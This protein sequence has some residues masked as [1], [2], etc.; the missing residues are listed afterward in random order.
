MAKTK[1]Q[2]EKDLEKI[3]KSLSEMK[4]LVFVDY[5]GV[6]VNEVN[7]L[8]KSLRDN[9]VEYYI[10]KR[11]LLKKAFKESSI[12]IDW[13][14]VPGPV[15]LA[16][17]LED[18]VMPAKLMYEF[19]KEHE[20]IELLGGVFENKFISQEKVLELAKL[21]SQEELMFKTVYLIKYPV[22][23]LVNSLKGSLNKLVYALKAVGETKA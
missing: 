17:G 19:Q 11:T 18:E 21:P 8:R 16:F 12:D 7:K 14:K 9:D 5:T 22:T 2:K 4:T 13:E 20:E 23:G 10:A 6:G 1:A 3:K 15:A